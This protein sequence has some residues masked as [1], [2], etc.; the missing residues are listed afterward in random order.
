M[1]FRKHWKWILMIVL[2]VALNF[3]SRD[4]ERV[5]SIYAQDIY[6]KVS[7][8]FQFLFGWLPFSAGDIIYSLLII[9]LIVSLSDSSKLLVK[10][11]RN[12]NP[13]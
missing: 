4:S 11:S 8:V 7:S 5:E 9:F 6:P 3:F 1:P 13:C 2:L 10:A 12:G